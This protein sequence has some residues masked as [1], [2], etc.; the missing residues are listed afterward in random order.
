MRVAQ[1]IRA[2]CIPRENGFSIIELMVAMVLSLLLLAGVLSVFA[3]SRSTYETVDRLS[4][5]QENGRFALDQIVNDVRSA[6]YLGCTRN[7]KYKITTLNSSTNLAWNFSQVISGFDAS[8]SSWSPAIDATVVTPATGSDVLV[9]RVPD[10]EATGIPLK[11]A[12]SASTSDLTV[13]HSTTASFASGDVVLLTNCEAEAA[14]QVTGYTS[15]TTATGDTV[16]H[17]SGGATT[18]SPGN[19]T[20]NLSYTFPANAEVTHVHTVIYYVRQSGSGTGTSC[21]ATNACSLWRRNGMNTPEEV[22]EGIDSMQVLYGVDT[23]GDGAA[24]TYSTAATVDTNNQWGSVLSVRIA[25][26]GQS[27]DEYG[28][29]KDANTYTLLDATAGPYNDRRMRKIFSSTTSLRNRAS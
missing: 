13:P 5:L 17:G 25:L 15:G 8:G 29:D 7:P 4:R 21:D 2:N 20:N 19:A 11:V 6:G 27:L 28:N 23:D 1:K 24:D 16:A 3:G 9:L 10:R 12:M 22:V 26:L 18:Y 14:L